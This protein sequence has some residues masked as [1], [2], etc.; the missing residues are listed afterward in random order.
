MAAS[1]HLSSFFRGFRV[2]GFWGLGFLLDVATLLSPRRMGGGLLLQ[3][4]ITPVLKAE[5]AA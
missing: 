4:N 5:N 3:D 2:L 1:V